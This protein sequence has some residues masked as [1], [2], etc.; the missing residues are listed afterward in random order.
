MRATVDLGGEDEEEVIS[1]RVVGRAGREIS[2]T[3]L[4]RR[5]VRC[6][7]DD[8]DDGDH[9]HTRTQRHNYRPRTAVV[10]CVVG[11]SR[12]RRRRGKT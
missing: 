5:W 4:V 3:R 7:K 6:V 8:D 11:S 12:G 1:D 10:M 9:T 2:S